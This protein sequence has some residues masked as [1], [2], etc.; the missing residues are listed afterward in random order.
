MEPI[1]ITCNPA[2]QEDDSANRLIS[3]ASAAATRTYA[4]I[5]VNFD[6]EVSGVCALLGTKPAS[7]ESCCDELNKHNGICERKDDGGCGT[8][9]AGNNNRCCR[10]RTACESDSYCKHYPNGDNYCVN[11]PTHKPVAGPKC[12]GGGGPISVSCKVHCPG[13]DIDLDSIYRHGV[14]CSASEAQEV[15]QWANQTCNVHCTKD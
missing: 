6:V 9:V 5:P 8:Y 13:S 4:T 2:S 1:T 11:P 12:P 3:A 7:G 15:V 14:F 10:H